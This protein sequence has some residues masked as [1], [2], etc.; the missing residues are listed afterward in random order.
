MKNLFAK[1]L[2]SLLAVS[3]LL[4]PMTASA[5]TGTGT[6]SLHLSPAAGSYTV[7]QTFTVTITETS[8]VAVAAVELD[9]NYPAGLLQCNGPASLGAF[10]T[11]YHNTCAG[12]ALSLG[13]GVQGTPVS[14]TQTVGSVSFT[15]LAAGNASLSIADASEID[16]TNV[17]NACDTTCASGATAASYSLAAPV[18]TGSTGSGSSSSSNTGSKSGS[19]SGSK[20]T[21]TTTTTTGTG[22]NTSTSVSTTKS[23]TQ[24]QSNRH[25]TPAP[26]PKH[27][28]YGHHT[29]AVTSTVSALVL[30]GA[31]AY[32]L[33]FRKRAE[34]VPAKVYKLVAAAKSK[35]AGKKASTHSKAATTA[36]KKTS[37]KK[38][39]AKKKA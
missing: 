9:V 28:F 34:L 13:V 3:S 27:N 14:G 16:D 36:T 17:A 39:T 10:A 22:S 7:G 31:A 8:S 33:I 1:S 37:V 26:Q 2:I 25:N 38:T 6:A 32:W 20:T 15:V 12:G 18:Q 21:T 29:G 4:V 11:S 5:A 24:T 35:T 30:L 23:Q 19:T